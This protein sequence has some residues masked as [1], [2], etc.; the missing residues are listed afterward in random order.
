[1]TTHILLDI[2]ALGKRPGCAI[3]ELAA[4]AFCPE[5]GK[6]GQAFNAIIEPQPP[7]MADLETLDWHKKQGTWPRPFAEGS[8]SI[9]SALVEFNAFAAGFGEVD[10]FWA[11][12][13]TYDFPILTAAYDFAGVDA[14]WDRQ[15]WKQ[16]CARTMWRAAFGDRKHGPRPHVAI[17]DCR[18]AVRDL[19]EA[20]GHADVEPPMR[21]ER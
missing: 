3:I 7:F 2:E 5:T 11:W 9:G 13:A 4:V 10:A 15:Y 6:I 18:A 20:L 21:K 1:M 8:H 19:L 16:Q 12:G 17:E 14:P